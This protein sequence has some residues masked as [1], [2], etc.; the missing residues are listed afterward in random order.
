MSN[1]D[2]RDRTDEFFKILQFMETKT[3]KR[4]TKSTQQQQP[5]K[6]EFSLIAHQIGIGINQ[7]AEKLQR[8]TECMQKRKKISS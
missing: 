8:L 2:P 4:N 5:P 1:I 7:T 6:S 3:P